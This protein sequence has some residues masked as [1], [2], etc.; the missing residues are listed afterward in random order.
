MV[1]FCPRCGGP[2]LPVKK[3]SEV[4]LRCT[5]CGFEVKVDKKAAEAYRLKYQVG[6]EKRVRTSKATIAKRLALSPEEREMLQEYYEV[7]LEAFQE[8]EGSGEE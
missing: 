1:R 8:E 7:F 5:R 4:Y 2:M 3:D 6:N